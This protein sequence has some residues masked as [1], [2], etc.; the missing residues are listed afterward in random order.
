MV[1]PHARGEDVRS[2]KGKLIGGGSPPRTW[3]RRKFIN[4]ELKRDGSPP[5]TWG[6]LSWEKKEA[7][8][9]WFTPTHV[10]K[11]S[12]L[13]YSLFPSVVHPHARGEDSFAHSH[14]YDSHGSPPRTWGRRVNFRRDV[15][16]ARFTPT[17]VGKT[18]FII[19]FSFSKRFTPTH[20][21]KT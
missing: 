7:S 21:G 14:T 6:R 1:H 19:V 4:C 20:V 10:G 11:T 13:L 12:T 8:P 16:R 3:G 9:K 15:S 17:H 18:P 5:R 2:K